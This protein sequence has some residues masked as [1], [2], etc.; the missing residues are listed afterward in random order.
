MTQRSPRAGFSLIEALV[1]LA[2]SGMALAI[3]FSIGV[4]AGDSGFA[5]GRRAMSSADLDVAMEDTR[6]LIRSIDVRPARTFTPGVDRPFAGGPEKFE[7]DV[8]MERATGCGPAGWAGRLTLAVE[9]AGNGRALICRAGSRETVLVRTPDPKAALSYSNDGRVWVASLTNQPGEGAGFR[10]LTALTLYV[11]FNGG[12]GA[13]ILD[14]A[15][16][17]RPESWARRVDGL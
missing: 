11:R 5:L 3:I 4:K 1:V 14:M 17:G 9:P 15:S 6:S 10:A 2:I 12:P 16:S 13:D 7:G 8:V